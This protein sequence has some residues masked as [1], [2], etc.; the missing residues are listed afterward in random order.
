MTRPRTPWTVAEDDAL[1]TR[2]TTGEKIIAGN[3]T[4]H[5]LK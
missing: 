4:R 1:R 3:I 5:V 2:T